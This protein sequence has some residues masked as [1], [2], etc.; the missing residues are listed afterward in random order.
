[1][2]SY[3]PLKLAIDQHHMLQINQLQ[4]T[5]PGQS[6]PVLH[7]ISLSLQAGEFCII[8]GSNGSGKSTLLKTLL[9][10]YIPDVGSIYLNNNNITQLPLYQRAKYI[11]CVFQDVLRGTVS[12][13]TVAE[14]LSLS[15]MRS[16]SASLKPYHQYQELF[17]QRLAY[18][19]M[20]LENYLSTPCAS[21]SGGQRQA[22]AFIMATLHSPDLLLLDEHCSA[23]DPKSS[24][25]IMESTAQFIAEFHIT[26]L[27]VTHNLRDALT[28][29][30]RLIMVHQGRIVF[31]VNGAEKQALT[32]QRLLDLFHRHEDQLLMGAGEDNTC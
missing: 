14:N 3:T 6:S 26:T 31:D 28:Y 17:K 20:G 7:D 1:M 15:Y 23:L 4:H 25:H 27:M 11:S 18:L 2:P 32:L 21:L 22:I 19:H 16:R 12:A 9:G 13:M 8:I 10:E 30:S 24:R 29:G 5:F